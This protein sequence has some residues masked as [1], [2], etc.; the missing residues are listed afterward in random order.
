[1]AL[2]RLF[3]CALGLWIL[4]LP[5]STAEADGLYASAT[6]KRRLQ[7]DVFPS[8]MPADQLG[9]RTFYI[10][11]ETQLYEA[12]L[13][14][15]AYSGITI[16]LPPL[17]LTLDRPLQLLTPT[18]IHGNASF[19]NDPV[20]I[21]RC[22]VEGMSLLALEGSSL[23]VRGVQL[24][25]CTR[26]GILIKSG[27]NATITVQNCRFLN[28][29]R[30]LVGTL[31]V[32]SSPSPS[33]H[34][35]RDHTHMNGTATSF[36]DLFLQAPD[37]VNVSAPDIVA[38]VS[39]DTAALAL[40]ATN[41]RGTLIIE[42]T[43][44]S[45]NYF[46]GTE[47]PIDAIQRRRQLRVKHGSDGNGSPHVPQDVA[48]TSAGDRECAGVTTWASGHCQSM[49]HQDHLS[50]GRGERPRRQLLDGTSPGSLPGLR[51][52]LQ[53]E[54]GS[55]GQTSMLLP[56]AQLIHPG[57]QVGHS[58]RGVCACIRTIGTVRLGCAWGV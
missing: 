51:R 23:V 50:Q 31:L 34:R 33:T 12:V 24:E 26:P 28:F 18:A 6:V 10:S 30:R 17:A 4:C 22:G 57:L 2:V 15:S 52:S 27:S 5:V 53:Q 42:N 20:S 29:T 56:R 8:P 47:S 45:N 54:P 1:M 43:T 21:L 36:V 48:D 44:F 41:F 40:H 11:T 38:P 16:V 7:Q 58:E 13:A 32:S 25:S 39:E 46:L 9:L 37:R 14:S 35:L 3:S 19:D 55:Q 49:E